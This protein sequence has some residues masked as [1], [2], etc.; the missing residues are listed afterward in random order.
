[1]NKIEPE[2]IPDTLEA[3]A[4]ALERVMLEISTIIRRQLSH[5]L[6]EFDLT[7]PQYMVMAVLHQRG[8]CT[9]TELADATYQ[10]SATM[11]G[12]VS[13]LVDR[14]LVLRERDPADRRALRVSLTAA[15]LELMEKINKQRQERFLAVLSNFSSSDRKELLRLV[16]AF[17]DVDVLSAED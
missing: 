1:M 12:I 15:G 11:T 16:A 10:V 3:Q 17:M 9:M 6:T 13:R 2:A 4:K 7:G 5:Q 14:D 8:K